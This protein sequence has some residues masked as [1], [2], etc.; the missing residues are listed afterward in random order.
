MIWKPKFEVFIYFGFQ[1]IF[2]LICRVLY[3]ILY[4]YIYIYIYIFFFFISYIFIDA[5]GWVISDVSFTFMGGGLATLDPLT[6]MTQLALILLQLPSRQLTCASTHK[7]KKTTEMA[8]YIILQQPIRAKL[9]WWLLN[10]SFKI[11]RPLYSCFSA[12][13]TLLFG[14]LFTLVCISSFFFLLRSIFPFFFK[15]KKRKKK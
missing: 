8:L 4:I 15:L 11:G 14:Y 1:I 2:L 3:Y 5:S 12:A 7:K 6:Q 10:L 9:F 13:I